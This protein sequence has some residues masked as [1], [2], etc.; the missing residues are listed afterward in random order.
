MLKM[1][2]AFGPRASMCGTMHV[3]FSPMSSGADDCASV[4]IPILV[5]QTDGKSRADMG[6][7]GGTVTHALKDIMCRLQENSACR[8]C[9]GGVG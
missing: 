9:Q 1:H 6:T 4:L 8:A 2:P 5:T 3:Q 7:E